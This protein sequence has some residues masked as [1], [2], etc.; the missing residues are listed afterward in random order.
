MTDKFE[1]IKAAGINL[2]VNYD[3][4]FISPWLESFEEELRHCQLFKHLSEFGRDQNEIKDRV[5]LLP[6]S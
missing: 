2:N 3:K 4:V 5:R 6:K 1:V